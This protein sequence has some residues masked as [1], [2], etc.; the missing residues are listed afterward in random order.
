M[1][2]L[3][4]AAT[5]LSGLVG[6]RNSDRSCISDFASGQ[7]GSTSTIYVTD[8]P[9][10]TP[11]NITAIKPADYSVLSDYVSDVLRRSKQEVL[12]EFV[13]RH[14]EL[15]RARTLLDD[16]NPVKG[17]NIFTNQITKA[18]RFVG[19]LIE[20]R[21]SDS[22][23]A[24]L[25]YV[26]VQFNTL[27]TALTLYLYETSQNDPIA[28]LTLSSHSKI[29]SL[30]WFESTMIARYKSSTGGTGQRYL[31]GYYENDLV[32]NAVSTSMHRC[33]GCD[34]GSSGWI[35]RYQQQVYVTGF[36]VNST[37]L[38]GTNL[39]NPNLIGEGDET[40][41]LHLKF[42]TEC[43][44]TDVVCDNKNLFAM[45]ISKKTAMNFYKD[46]HNSTNISREADM[47]RDRAMTNY[48][49]AKEEYDQ[50]L[51]GI[52]IDFTDIDNYCLPCSQRE[53]RTATI[54]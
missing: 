48:A 20:P 10:I 11:T 38:S 34:G 43:E 13:N 9:A 30:Q 42:Y 39:P 40:F 24:V 21:K 37:G 35:E 7:T 17:V 28:T 54:R 53:L 14:K 6:F 2:D 52:R 4:T 44:I 16:V 19:I 50:L 33:S 12:Q 5:C 27:N 3:S 32:G 36:S 22:I 29:L 18:G 46:G 51:R 25:K 15:T 45:A 8:E 31:L 49:V 47:F 26:G 41:G 1:I 23:A